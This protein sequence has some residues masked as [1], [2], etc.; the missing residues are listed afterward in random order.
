MRG[1]A[2]PVIRVLTREDFEQRAGPSVMQVGCG[3]VYAAKRGG[4]EVAPLPLEL[5]PAGTHIVNQPIGIKGSRV[6]AGAACQG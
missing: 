2:V 1:D 6:A 5:S 3:L 4:V